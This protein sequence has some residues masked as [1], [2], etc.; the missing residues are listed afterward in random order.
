MS[1]QQGEGKN[2]DKVTVLSRLEGVVSLKEG[3]GG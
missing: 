1:E 3:V 2:A